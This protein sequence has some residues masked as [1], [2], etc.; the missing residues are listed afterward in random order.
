MDSLDQS[1]IDQGIQQVIGF[2]QAEFEPFGQHPLGG[3][4]FPPKPGGFLDDF[5][6]F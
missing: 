2:S 6:P 5:R 4:G 1:L 3:K